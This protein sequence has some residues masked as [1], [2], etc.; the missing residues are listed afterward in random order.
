MSDFIFES[1]EIWKYAVEVTIKLLEIADLL[2]NKKLYGFANQ[3][4]NSSLSITS[5]IAEGSGS[6]SD[7]DFGVFLNYSRRSVFECANIILVLY[8]KNYIKE[9]IKLQR[10][11]ELDI[12]SKRITAFR[13]SLKH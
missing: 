1:L 2:D 9:E 12:L 10:L 13:R 7:K 5:N 11:S 4:R 8:F 3:L 6:F